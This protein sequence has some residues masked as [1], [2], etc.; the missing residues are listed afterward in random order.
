MRRCESLRE[1][2]ETVRDPCQDLRLQSFSVASAELAVSSS[3]RISGIKN[4]SQ[5]KLATPVKTKISSDSCTTIEVKVTYRTSTVKKQ[6]YQVELYLFCP[7]ELLPVKSDFYAQLWQVIRL[8]S[9]KVPSL[10]ELSAGTG[11]AHIIPLIQSRLKAHQMMHEGEGQKVS[12]KEKDSCVEAEALIIQQFRLFV[13]MMRASIRKQSAGII[14]AAKAAGAGLSDH[15]DSPHIQSII[16]LVAETLEAITSLRAAVLSMI[17]RVQACEW[18]EGPDASKDLLQAWKLVDEFALAEADRSLLKLLLELERLQAEKQ[19]LVSACNATPTANKPRPLPPTHPGLSNMMQLAE[20]FLIPTPELQSALSGKLDSN[21]HRAGLATACQLVRACII[22]LEDDRRRQGY[23][24]SI[25][26]PNAP[27]GNEAYTNRLKVLKHNARAAVSLKPEVLKPSFL[28]ADLVG[29][30]IAGVAMATA[31]VGTWLAFGVAN[32]RN[33]FQAVYI[34]IIIVFYMLKDRI[35]EWGKRYLQ[36]IAEWF[37]LEFPDRIVNVTDRRGCK[38]GQCKEATKISGAS[39][40]NKHVLLMRHHDKGH[41]PS[42]FHETKPEKVLAYRR[43]MYVLW[44]HVDPQLQGVDGLDDVLQVDLSW[45]T[46]RMQPSTESHY[47]L[48]SAASGSHAEKIRCARVY[49]INLVLRVRTRIAD[50]QDDRSM[51]IHR[52]RI[53]MD[54]NGIKRLEAA[55]QQLHYQGR[56]QSVHVPLPTLPAMPAFVRMT[57]SPRASSGSSTTQQ[58]KTSKSLDHIV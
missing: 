3:I 9:P 29:S 19:L 34:A 25:L 15:L 1:F 46:R 54:K 27:Q 52:A 32:A 43:R 38:V 31:V 50:V 36:P 14:K 2:Q 45:L 10:G 39:S 8:H 7:E 37:G 35:K 17:D 21:G 28:L 13:C 41:I 20:S 23:S 44:P 18:C 53:I 22:E 56:R 6:L 5:D 48:S 33:Q 51:Q 55:D 49:H 4:E 12:K 16:R 58:L 11:P 30:T 26:S 57:S 42:H 47:C 24:E 40:V